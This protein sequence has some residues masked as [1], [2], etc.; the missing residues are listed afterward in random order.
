VIQIVEG[1]A[2]GFRC[3]T[4]TPSNKSWSAR[5][6]DEGEEF[7]HWALRALEHPAALPR[8][9]VM[10]HDDPEALELGDR[11]VVWLGG[12]AVVFWNRWRAANSNKQS[13]VS[14]NPRIRRLE[15]RAGWGMS[16]QTPRRA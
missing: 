7:P 3:N 1:A 13:S 11:F 12:A 15:D 6:A 14:P 8:P 5:A 9:R 2:T 10:T 4:A 16:N